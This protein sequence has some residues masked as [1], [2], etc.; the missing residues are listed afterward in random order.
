MKKASCML[1]LLLGFG[2]LAFA[3]DPDFS[4]DWEML[5]ENGILHGKSVQLEATD[6]DYGIF[7][8]HIE[9]RLVVES[10]CATCG[11]PI[12]EYIIDGRERNVPN[13]QNLKA[14]YSARWA[15]QSLIINQGIGGSTPFGTGSF[16]TRQVWA[17]SA[18]KQTLTISTSA[19]SS[20]GEIA[21]M[22][23]YQRLQ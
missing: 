23:V 19:S 9:N 8:T 3:A 13:K 6:K 1:W 14:L 20:D 7:I 21:L 18:D 11:N 5:S 12:R 22:K 10:R 15:G 4:G 17:L 16:I 2:H